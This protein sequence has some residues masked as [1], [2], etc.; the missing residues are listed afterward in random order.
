M[1]PDS[2]IVGYSL[3]VVVVFPSQPFP[4]MRDE[5]PVKIFVFE[6]VEDGDVEMS[7]EKDV[8]IEIFGAVN[9]AGVDAVIADGED[10][11]HGLAFRLQR[12]LKIVVWYG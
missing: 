8:R 1:G 3:E 5:Q 11:L 12:S 6:S 9:P 7:L 4:H 2:G 10:V